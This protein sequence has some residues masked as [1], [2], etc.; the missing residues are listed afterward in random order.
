MLAAVAACSSGSGG[1]DDAGGDSARGDGG[2]GETEPAGAEFVY[3]GDDWARAEP[4]DEGF[5]AARLDQVAA[6][7]EEAGSNCLVV[8]RRGRLVAEWYWNGTE[9]ATAQE[10]FSATK[11][12]GSTLVGIA[13]AE[14]DLDIDDRAS[15]YIRQWQGT[16]SEDVTVRQILSN[17]SGRHWDAATDYGQLPLQQDTTGFGI[18][19]DQQED[20]GTRWAYNNAAIQ[21]L[22]AVLRRATG[23]D[24]AAFADERLLGPI[25]MDESQMGH[26]PA[27][28]TLIFMGLRSTCQDMAR[29]GYLFLRRG[30]WDGEQVVPEDWVE[31]ATGRPSQDLMAGYGLLWWLNRRGP[32][33]GPLAATGGGGEAGGEAAEGQ[34]VQGA[35]EDMFWALGLGGQVIS[36]DPGS[37]TVVVRLGPPSPPAGVPGYGPGDAAE[38]VTEALT[39]P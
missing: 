37:E 5:D 16:P 2:P 26:D 38:V 36:V 12:Y 18:G 28:N 15:D 31:E 32:I 8:T 21:T 34:M 30:A 20:P 19:L 24:P 39:E 35:P 27:G 4:A 6:R 3:P 22:D 7:A 17:D 10:V 9:P 13:Q 33:L 25:G 11:S 14:G 29:F 23:E 1:G